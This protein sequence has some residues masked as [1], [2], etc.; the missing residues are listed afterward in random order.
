MLNK[1]DLLIILLTALLA[2]ML[3]TLGYLFVSAHAQLSIE[4]TLEDLADAG[5][6]NCEVLQINEFLYAPVRLE[7]EHEKAT[8]KVPDI[9]ARDPAS[10]P[11]YE[12]RPDAFIFETGNFTDSYEFEIIW[13]YDVPSEAPKQVFYRIFTAEDIL[14]FEGNWVST[15]NQFCRVFSFKVEAQP[16]FPTAEEINEANRDSFRE[17][18][19]SIVV[20][21]GSVGSVVI[22]LFIISLSTATFVGIALIINWHNIRKIKYSVSEPMKKYKEIAKRFTHLIEN[23]QM[24]SHGMAQDKTETM[25]MVKMAI[26]DLKFAQNDIVLQSEQ[27]KNAR[28]EQIEQEIKTEKSGLNIFKF[29]K[30]KPLQKIGKELPLE[31]HTQQEWEKIYIKQTREENQKLR[32]EYEAEYAVTPTEDIAVKCRALFEVLLKQV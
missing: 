30:K 16:Q 3:F 8:T 9:K 13:D 18:L 7:L 4:G 2:V 27:F 5:N 32:N 22:I 23:L 10:E 6:P 25:E 31:A 28:T 1:N 17:I 20:E 15:D 12:A 21:V 14:T 29:L 26:N 11:Q 24:L 19:G